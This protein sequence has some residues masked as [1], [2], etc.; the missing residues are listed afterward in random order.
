MAYDGSPLLATPASR[1]ADA[2]LHFAQFARL[3]AAQASG[4]DAAICTSIV[5]LAA[6]LTPQAATN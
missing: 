6:T 5:E 3:T 2:K 4:D 1:A